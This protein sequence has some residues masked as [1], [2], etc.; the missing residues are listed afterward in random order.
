M[1][2]ESGG[3]GGPTLVLLHGL[4]ANA[5]VWRNLLPFV[6]KTWPGRWM[7]PD[8]PGHGRS[9]AASLY[10]YGAHA[11]AVAGLIGQGVEVAIIGHSMGGVIALMLATGWFGVSVTRVLAVG[12]KLRWSAEDIAGMAHLAET[13]A[14]WFDDRSAVLERYLRVSGLSGLVTP[15]SDLAQSGII[16][17]SGR[18]RLAS[19]PRVHL[20][21]APPIDHLMGVIQVPVHFAAGATDQMASLHDMRRYDPSAEII[22]NA[23][24]NAHVERPEKLWALFEQMAGTP[25]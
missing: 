10:S 6:E 18:F 5:A 19:D 14:R 25:A 22:T 2:V 15:D 11:A 3:S 23:G 21:G 13:P 7:A 17:E 4:G 1:Y 24:H 12:V 8:L 9:P 20:V 16:E